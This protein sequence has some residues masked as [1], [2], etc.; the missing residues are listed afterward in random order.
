MVILISFLSILSGFFYWVGGQ[1]KDVI[2]WADTKVRDLGIPT[3]GVI[4]MT[5][6]HG[7]HWIYLLCFFMIFGAQTTYFKKKGTDAKWY[8]WLFVGLAFSI[9]WISY[10]IVFHNWSGF[11]YRSIVVTIFTM[12]WSES[13]SNDFA[14]E[15]GRGFIQSIT[16]FLL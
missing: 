6:L 12:I 3:I 5:L 8:H 14:E 7:W 1:S 4:I 10:A 15:L 16:L 11:L 9:A 2:K 13:I